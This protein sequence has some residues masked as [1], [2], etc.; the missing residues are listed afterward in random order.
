MSLLDYVRLLENRDNRTR[1]QQVLA[2]LK[3][4][5]IEPIVQQS[6]LP[7]VSNIVVDFLPEPKT[8]R[9]LFSAHYDAAPGSPGA[10]DNA[11]GVAVLLGLCHQLKDSRLPV[12]VVFFDREEAWLRTPLIRLGL[13][14][15]L[16]YVWK[17]DL[18][19]VAAVYNLEFCGRGDCLGIWPVKDRE[20][21][22]VALKEVEAAATRLGL[23]FRTAHI[24]WFFLNSDHL[25]F[26]LRGLANA[27]TL[28][29]LPASQVPVLERWIQDL[30]LRRRLFGRRP[31]LP[32]PLSFIHTPEDTSSR[33]NEDSLGLMLALLLKLCQRWPI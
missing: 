26:R 31:P 6:R 13:L 30:S 20:R 8:K 11:S 16:Y 28:S 29:L 10:N 24:P 21:H 1:R 3:E 27:L 33:L 2:I 14:G 15:S 19:T 22:L 17:A 7:R 25:S 9:W 4:L 12:R 23:P 18:K 32:E 5:G